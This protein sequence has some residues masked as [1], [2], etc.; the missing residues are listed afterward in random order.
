MKTLAIASIAL[1]MSLCSKTDIVCPEQDVYNK[2][3][4]QLSDEKEQEQKLIMIRD[5]YPKTDTVKIDS[6]NQL[7]LAHF[8]MEN[9]IQLNMKNELSSSPCIKP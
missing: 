1:L 2:Y 5:S 7:I 8:T 6:I 9:S 3:K 4:Q